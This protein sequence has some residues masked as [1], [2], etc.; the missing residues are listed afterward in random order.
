MA[1]KQLLF[2]LLALVLMWGLL[3]FSIPL[4][5]QHDEQPAG[6]DILLTATNYLPVDTGIRWVYTGSGERYSCRQVWAS[7][8]SGQRIQLMQENN[9]ET[10]V[11]VLEAGEKGIKRVFQKRQVKD[12]ANYVSE[13]NDRTVLLSDPVRVGAVW[14]HSGEVRTIT[15]IVDGFRVPA[16]SF[17]RVVEVEV[18]RDSGDVTT[19]Y[20]APGVGL[21]KSTD[22]NGAISEL[23]FFSRGFDPKES[24]RSL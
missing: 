9:G 17:D 18:V 2:G 15:D 6:V 4:T 1:S 3:T 5:N 21:I 11:C 8:R 24:G 22:S 10:S 20:W 14:K 13:Q 23:V 19:E 12:T 16:G 7:H